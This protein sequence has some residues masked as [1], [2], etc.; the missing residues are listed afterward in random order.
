MKIAFVAN[1]CWNIFNFRKGLVFHFL[2][3]GDEV[4]VLAPHDEYS[5]A[6]VKWGATWINTPLDST[7]VNPIKDLKYFRVLRSALQKYK[8]DVALAYTIKSNIYSCL[9]GNFSNVPVICNVS[10]L[11]TVFLVEGV[12]GQIAMF[13]Y[14]VAFRSASHVFFQNEDDQELFLSNVNLARE[15]IG[16]LPGSGI[17][18]EEFKSQPLLT[19]DKVRFLM[20]SRVIIE[21]GVE[22]YA[23]AAAYFKDDD[24]VSFSL[25][26]KFDEDHARS[27]EKSKLD[28][29][30]NNEILDY[31]PHSDEIQNLISDHDVLV[32]P[33]YREGTPRTLLEGA[34]MGRPLLASDVPGCREVVCDGFNGFLFEV[35]NSKSLI[36]KIKL[37]LSLKPEEREQLAANS[38][39]LV[40]ETFDEQ[41]V[42]DEYE[43]IIHGIVKP[44]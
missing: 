35:K 17:N 19:S 33:S 28:Q 5:D 16:L 4:I 41:I 39:K 26:G 23:E 29:W 30:I 18:L 3:R 24:R 8:P 1:S 44:A 14:R 11:G 27:I 22:D 15:R 12:V 10:G 37:Y 34:A 38:R 6:I 2:N 25:V 32:L 9:A 13:L 36:D 31:Q 40:E 7:G 21:K 43:K 20:V 42:I